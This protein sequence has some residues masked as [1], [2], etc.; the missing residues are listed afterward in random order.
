MPFVSV[1]N[2]MPIIY[3]ETNNDSSFA[4]YQTIARVNADLFP[5]G[6]LV[7]FEL[8]YHDL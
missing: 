6:P 5:I 3:I 8:K 1:C 4:L 7:N 2:E